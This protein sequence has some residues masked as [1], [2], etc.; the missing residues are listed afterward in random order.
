MRIIEGTYFKFIYTKVR[1]SR[2]LFTNTIDSHRR[3]R[4]STV[5]SLVNLWRNLL[6]LSSQFLL[7]PIPVISILFQILAQKNRN[8]IIHMPEE[9][10][11]IQ[12]KAVLIGYQI[13]CQTKVTVPSRT[14]NLIYKAQQKKTA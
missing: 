11:N 3:H 14:T 9:Q 2:N 13:H 12:V 4:S 10:V 7:N 5:N 1:K 6:Y 8:T